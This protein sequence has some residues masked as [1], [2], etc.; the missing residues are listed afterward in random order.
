MLALA[1][2]SASAQDEERGLKLNTPDAY[3]GL[4]L[5]SPLE[6]GNTYLID[7]D[8]R[9]VH[10][11]ISDYR[12]SAVY[13]LPNGHILRTAGYGLQGNGTFHGGGSGYRLEEFD[14]DGNKV[15]EYIYASD[16]HLMH[17][18]VEPMPNGNVLILAYEMKTKEE[19]IQAGRNPEVLRDGEIWS[20][21]IIEVKPTHPTGGE[22]VWRW[23]LW[24]HLI[25]DFDPAKDNYGDV[26]AHPERVDIDPPGFWLDRVS[27]EELE[28]LQALGYVGEDDA[29]KQ[30]QP[31]RQGGGADW[32][33]TNAIAYNPQHDLIALSVLGNNE[34]WIL[35]HSTT[36]EEARGHT[37]GT[38][39]KGGDL[40]YRWGNPL[41]YRLGT[42]SDQRL[43]AQHNVH[44]IPD[45]LPGAGDILVFNN[46]RGRPDGPFSSADQVHLPFTP[47]VG[48]HREE[49]KP[50]GPT[51]PTWQYTAP[52]KKDFNSI[53]ISS[54]QRLPNGNTLIC[55][56][57]QGTFFEVT[58]DK[59]EVWRY[60]NPANPPAP[61]PK[62]GERAPN[63]AFLRFTVFR[64]ARYPFDYPAFA[65][66]DLTPGPLL[67]DYLKDHPAKS[68][69]NLEDDFPDIKS[70]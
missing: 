49:G 52:N 13:L 21:H 12:P 16:K 14:W 46:G 61:E 68:G 6:S 41:A 10:E 60:I 35:D 31:N 42:E 2:T 24:D 19:S 15:W 5:F 53:F 34:L 9:L 62:E 43:F 22:I 40:L 7:N 38:Y 28:Q 66:R 39:G 18:D 27:P 51:E 70:K 20:E 8:G 32:L 17:H 33:H 45:G 30:K 55:A 58:P 59:K 69:K 26:A 48:F 36:I 1:T 50:W 47:R 44:W 64:V 57:A 3:P 23:H 29:K 54:A 65:G 63:N 56:G 25:Q 37:G 11:W 4:N 67:T